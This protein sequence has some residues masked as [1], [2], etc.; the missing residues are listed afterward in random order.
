M[1]IKILT[2]LSILILI[3]TGCPS[4]K[5]QQ[6]Q[7]ERDQLRTTYEESRRKND[8]LTLKNTLAREIQGTWQFLDIELLEGDLSNEIKTAAVALAALSRKDLTIRF[9][10]QSNVRFYEG[11][12][13]STNVAGEW[14]IAVMRIAEELIP[15]LKLNRDSGIAPEQFLFNRRSASQ[16]LISVQDDRLYLT[17]G[18]GQLLTPAGWA[19]VGGTRHSFK[20]IK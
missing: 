5:Y 12:N 18:Y 15:M 9:F 7:N 10:E 11:N 17:V 6:M 2:S 13:G 16:T 1:R 14:N 8:R 3:F 19:Q 4:A 20:R